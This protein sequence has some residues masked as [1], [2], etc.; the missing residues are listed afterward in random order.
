MK[1]A[2]ACALTT[3]CTVKL[4]ADSEC[5]SIHHI[6][7]AAVVWKEEEAQKSPLSGPGHSDLMPILDG[8]VTDMLASVKGKEAINV[9]FYELHSVHPQVEN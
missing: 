9:S 1:C 4:P 3:G 8:D 5:F 7:G 2:R 6:D